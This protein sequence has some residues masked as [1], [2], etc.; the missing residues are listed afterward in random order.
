MVWVLLAVDASASSRFAVPPASQPPAVATM[1]RHRARPTLLNPR[2]QSG[3]VW[4]MRMLAEAGRFPT[5]RCTREWRGPY[6][7]WMTCADVWHTDPEPMPPPPPWWAFW[8]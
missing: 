1:Q 3:R 5:Q 4:N 8:R 7:T 2:S 6:V